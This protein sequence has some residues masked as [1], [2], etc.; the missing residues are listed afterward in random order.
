MWEVPFGA[1]HDYRLIVMQNFLDCHLKNNSQAQ[2]TQTYLTKLL[3]MDRSSI[4]ESFA[5]VMI[6]SFECLFCSAVQT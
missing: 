5:P 6:P 3:I 4:I 2:V 1:M